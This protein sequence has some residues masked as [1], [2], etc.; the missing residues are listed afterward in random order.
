MAVALSGADADADDQ[1]QELRSEITADRDQ[2]TELATL[3]ADRSISAAEWKVAR[4][5]IES[6]IKQNERHVGRLTNTTVLDG[7]IGN[8]DQLRTEWSTLNLTR[9]ATIIKAVLDYAI[10]DAAKIAGG[11]FDPDRVRPVWRI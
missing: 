4:E 1:A 6:R 7:Y 3:Y 10:I 8:S 9:Q 2:L 11:A 5:R